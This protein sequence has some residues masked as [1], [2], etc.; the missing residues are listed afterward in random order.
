MRLNLLAFALL[1]FSSCSLTKLPLQP[2]L[3]QNTSTYSQNLKA[4]PYANYHGVQISPTMVKLEGEGMFY[5]FEKIDLTPSTKSITKIK[6]RYM[7]D[8]DVYVYKEIEFNEPNMILMGGA[9]VGTA[10]ST[11]KLLFI[12]P[13]SDSAM[14]AV[15]VESA[16]QLEFNDAAK[17]VKDITENGFPKGVVTGKDAQQVDFVGRPLELGNVC[18][19]FAPH[20]ITCTGLGELRWSMF[21]DEEEASITMQVNIATDEI[22]GAAVLSKD[23]SVMVTFEG[24]KVKATKMVFKGTADAGSNKVVYYLY[25]TLRGYPMFCSVSF[26]EDEIK[27]NGLSPLAAKVMSIP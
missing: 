7:A 4:T 16:F 25:T 1:L 5:T 10:F 11:T 18:G 19:W 22:L 3:A 26:T 20:H 15:T 8:G 9:D 2:D 12:V 14:Y 21:K 23:E 27:T 17:I 6:N 13:S 24:Q